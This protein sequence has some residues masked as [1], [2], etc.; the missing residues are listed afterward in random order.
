M[1]NADFA[2]RVTCFGCSRGLHRV[3]RKKTRLR[4]V[5]LSENA[6]KNV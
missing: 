2:I 1:D 4:K 3:R 5:E 6:Q